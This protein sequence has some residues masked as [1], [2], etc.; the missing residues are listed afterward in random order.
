[1]PSPQVTLLPLLLPQPTSAAIA[2]TE[3]RIRI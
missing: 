3:I 2:A 1:V